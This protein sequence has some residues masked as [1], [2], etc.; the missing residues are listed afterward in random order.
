MTGSASFSQQGDTI[1]LTLEVAGAT[2]G[3]H[4]VHLHVFGDC[5]A[6]DA[7]SAGGHWNPMD[8]DHGKWGEEPYHRG[9]I[10]NLEVGEDGTGSLTHESAEWTFGGDPATE[11]LGRAVIVH[12]DVDDYGQPTGN[13]GGRVAC[14]TIQYD[15]SAASGSAD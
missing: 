7:T 15:I 13:A 4:A 5:S 14:G 12:A 11:I 1:V 8:V 3:P 10:G 9:D 2:P 6:D